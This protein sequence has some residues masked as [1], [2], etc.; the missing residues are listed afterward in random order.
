MFIFFSGN[1]ALLYQMVLEELFEHITLFDN[2]PASG[3]AL[4][5]AADICGI[6]KTDIITL[7]RITLS[8]FFFFMLQVTFP[9]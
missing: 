8:R 9:D 3:D 5:T 7:C 4:V 1:F 6:K 2:F